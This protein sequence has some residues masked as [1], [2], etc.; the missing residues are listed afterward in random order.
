MT[1][2]LKTTYATWSAICEPGDEFGGMLRSALGA[3]EAL[4]L[5]KRREATMLAHAIKSSHLGE[6]AGYRFGDLSKTCID[7]LERWLPR[8]DRASQSADLRHSIRKLQLITPE[9]NSWPKQIDD[10]GWAAPAALWVEG[11]LGLLEKTA[12]SIA[13]VGARSSTKYGEWVTSEFVAEVALKEYC[14]IS[15]GAYGIDGAAHRAALALSAT[16]VAVLA[17]G[18]DRLYPSGHQNLL[19]EISRNG[20]LVSELPPGSSPTKWRFLQRNRLIAAITRATLVIEAGF[21]SGS[22]NTANHAVN[23]GRQVG[24]VPGPITS[25]SSAGCHR[26]IRDGVA[27]LVSSGHDVLELLGHGTSF[28]DSHASMGALETRA[29][30]ALGKNPKMLSDV[31]SVAGLTIS[32]ASTALVS[33]ELLGLA[34]SAY[35]KW[36][37]AA[38]NL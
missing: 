5:L 17:G 14:V 38:S 12:K 35:G 27:T 13:M 11:E 36:S 2:D 24:A 32:E 6:E 30:D 15:G 22:I 18:L 16:T 4:Q 1:S 20:L 7:A 23:L 3:S 19:L 29:L 9:C 10:L 28:E 8:L 37:R 26:L 34:V 25:P 31:A 21:R 33:L